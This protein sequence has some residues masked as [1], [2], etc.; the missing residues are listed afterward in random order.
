L[1]DPNR[2]VLDLE[3]ASSHINFRELQ[4]IEPVR[5][6]RSGLRGNGSLRVVLDVDGDVAASKAFVAQS[7]GGY[8]TVFV[9]VPKSHETLRTSYPVT[10]AD[11]S[12]RD[13]VVAISAGHGGNDPGGIGYDGILQE[14]NIT[15]DIARQLYDYLETLPGFSPVMIRDDDVYVKLQRRSQIAREHRADLFV[16]IHTD[17]YKNSSANGLTIYALSGDRADRENARR[18]AEKENSSD[19]IG[20][21]GN[22]IQL[23]AWDD[24]VALTLVSLQ[25]SW[26]MEQSLEVARTF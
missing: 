10:E 5:G 6:L 1:S 15:L 18:V 25:M 16:A 24:D 13:V 4:S 3:N 9:D 19:L 26:S 7:T 17:W 12:K 14:K 11:E 22:D 20:G 8:F 21:I 23:D 2:I